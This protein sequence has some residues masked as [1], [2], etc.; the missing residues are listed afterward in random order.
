MQQVTQE[1]ILTDVPT[2]QLKPELHQRG[3]EIA[4]RLNKST[5]LLYEEILEAGIN[6]LKAE[7]DNEGLEDIADM[8]ESLENDEWVNLD[9]I[10]DLRERLNVRS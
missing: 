1:K 4:R 5:N 10:I 9:E 3:K 2:F 8:R 7:L 6:A